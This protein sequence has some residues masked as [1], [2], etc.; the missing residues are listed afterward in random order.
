MATFASLAGV[1]LLD[2]DRAG[3]PITFDS[4]DISPVLFDTGKDPRTTWSYFT[5]DELSSGTVRFGHYSQKGRSVRD[6]PMDD[7]RRCGAD[8]NCRS[9]PWIFL[10]RNSNNGGV[11][12]TCDSVRRRARIFSP[13]VR[14]VIFYFANFL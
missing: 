11:D 4:Y 14:D 8:A 10:D 13:I 5:E 7:D 2:K 1:K 9:A 12:H 3:E 6:H